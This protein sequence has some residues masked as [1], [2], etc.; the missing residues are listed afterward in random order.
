VF[1]A[2]LMGA[3]RPAW[4]PY[5]D[6]RSAVLSATYRLILAADQQAAGAG[7]RQRPPALGRL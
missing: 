6:P 5:A 1:R 3:A 2:E 4:A 7:E